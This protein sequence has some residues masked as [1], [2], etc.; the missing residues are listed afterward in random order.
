MIGKVIK[1]T[2]GHEGVVIGDGVNRWQGIPLSYGHT[3]VIINTEGHSDTGGS[4][5][6]YI[7]WVHKGSIV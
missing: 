4:L 5:G 1:T 3:G 2:D 7:R 6:K